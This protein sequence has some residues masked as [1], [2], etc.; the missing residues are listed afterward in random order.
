VGRK[1]LAATRAAGG[2]WLGGSPDQWAEELT[3]AVLDHQA[4]GFILFSPPGGTPDPATLAVWAQEIAPAV[5]AARL[6]SHPGGGHRPDGP[7]P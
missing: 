6:A 3:G 5:R 1:S 2:R 7:Q 4:S